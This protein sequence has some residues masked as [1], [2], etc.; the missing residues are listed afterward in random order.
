MAGLKITRVPQQFLL[1]QVR[2][3]SEM[4]W[5]DN[6]CGNA[7]RLGLTLWAITLGGWIFYVRQLPPQVPLFYSRPWGEMQLTSPLGLGWL[8][9]VSLMVLMIN[10]LVAGRVFRI[11]KLL[12]RIMSV[13]AALVSFLV[14][15]AL[16][17][18]LW[19]VT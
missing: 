2:R 4:V 12:A 6:V 15:I 5:H 10:N 7:L 17:R 19:L 3:E 16:I 18:I 14:T 1:S 13:A 8:A 11:D 9:A